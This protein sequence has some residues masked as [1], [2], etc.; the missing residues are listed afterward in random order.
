MICG[1]RWYVPPFRAWLLLITYSWQGWRGHVKARPF[2]YALREFYCAKP[3]GWNKAKDHDTGK[4]SLLEY[5]DFPRLRHLLEV[6]DDDASGLV[7]VSEINHFTSS[8]PRDWA[9]VHFS[10]LSHLITL[11][12]PSLSDWIIYWAV[13]RRSFAELPSFCP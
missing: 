8:R 5:I 11:M 4:T 3:V 6:F 13:G 12:N 9:Y 10:L 2:V 1:R 7:T